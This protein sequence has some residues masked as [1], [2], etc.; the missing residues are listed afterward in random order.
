MKSSEIRKKYIE[1]FK[2]NNHEEIINFSLIPENDPTVLFTTAGMHPLVPYLLGQ[3]HPQGRRLVNVQKC[4][5]TQDIDEVGDDSHLTFFEMLGNWSLGDY[6]KKE[7]IRLSFEFLTK[8]L[9]IPKERIAITIFRGDKDAPKDTESESI[10]LSLGIPEERIKALPKK[11]NWWGPAGEFGPCGPD[12]EMFVYSLKKAPREFNP[13]DKKWIEVG[14]DVFMQYN[15]TSKGYEELRQKNVDFGGGVERLSMILQDKDN[16]FETDLFINA[17]KKIKSLSERNDDRVFRIIADHLR[18]SCFILAELIKPSN[19]EQG[20]ILRRLLRR[21]IRYGRLIGIKENF[22]PEILEIIINDYRKE[23]PYLEENKDFILQQAK[24]E[25]EKFKTSLEKGLLEFNKINFRN[26]ISGKDAFYL[27]QSFGFPIEIIKDL[28][29]EKGLIVGEKEFNE[30]FEKHQEVSRVGA[31]KKFKSGLADHSEQTTKL[32]TATHLLLQALKE[33]LGKDV[34]Q[35]GSNITPERTRFD[36]SFPRKLTE[37]EIKKVEIKVN[38]II[39]KDLPITREEMPFKEAMKKGVN[40]FFKEKYPEVV[41]VYYV[42]DF[43]KEV[44]TG[45]HVTHTGILGKFKITKEESSS[46][47]VRRIKAILE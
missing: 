20:Y 25:E 41:S 21:S 40:A 9:N 17:I 36:F 42:G 11:E 8:E 19:V 44:C 28:A 14:N 27:Y 12:T 35:M 6:W 43:S 39:R 2:K 3:K 46:A 24:L 29:R 47:G 33:V 38:D 15:K 13:D 37:E 7:A 31:E 16:V 23:Y 34:K 32:H 10:W 4:I 5:R 18:T 30:E 45:P 26:K 1:F 22:I